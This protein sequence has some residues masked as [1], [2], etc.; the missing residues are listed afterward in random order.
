[1]NSTKKQARVA[2]LLYL[3]ASIPAPFGL[4]YVP[5]KLIVPGDAGATANHVRLPRPF[6][7]SASR[8]N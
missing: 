6:S 7:A 2:G 8:A 5:G 4:I 1:M 3:L